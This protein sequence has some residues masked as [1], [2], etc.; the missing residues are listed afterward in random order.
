MATDYIKRLMFLVR[1]F[2]PKLLPPIS[3]RMESGKL[4]H[5][6]TGC[7]LVFFGRACLTEQRR[8]TIVGVFRGGNRGNCPAFPSGQIFPKK[9]NFLNKLVFLVKNGILLP[10]PLKLSYFIFYFFFSF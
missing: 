7:P 5:P 2:R 4:V 9:V 8:L 3:T 10:P 6:Y 1:N